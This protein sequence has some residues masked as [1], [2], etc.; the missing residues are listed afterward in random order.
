MFKLPT[1]AWK[2]LNKEKNNDNS[3]WYSFEAKI[4]SDSYGVYKET[5][6]SKVRDG[7]EVKVELET[8]ERSK[9]VDLYAFAV[10]AKEEYFK[11]QKTVGHIPRRIS[12]HLY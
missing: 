5:F 6:W 2:L 11:G 4:A 7:G 12:R 3:R 1:L 9:N 10:C 8:S